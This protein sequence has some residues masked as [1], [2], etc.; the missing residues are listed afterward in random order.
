M[1]VREHRDDLTL[2]AQVLVTAIKLLLLGVASAFWMVQIVRGGHYRALAESNRLRSLPIQAPRGLIYDR[3][4][5]ILVEN[6]P[7]YDLLLDRGRSEDLTASLEHAATLLGRSAEELGATMERRRGANPFKPALVGEN[8]T[9]AEV[10][11]VSATGL[12]HPEFEIQVRHLRLYRLGYQTAH[13]LGH[14]GEVGAAELARPDSPYEP[15]DLVGRKGV[16]LVYDRQLQGRD[17][18]RVVVVDSRGKPLEEYS[19]KPAQAG[20]SLTLTLDVDLQ[21][22]AVRLMGDHVGVVVA[23][24]PR[25]GEVLALVSSPSYNP[26]H[27]A[28][29]LAAEEWRQLL[30]EPHDPLQNRA[31]QSSYSPGSLFKIVMA[32]AGLSEGVVRP[33]DTTYCSGATTLYNHRFRCWKR[34]GHGWMNLQQAI[35]HSCDVYFYYLGQKLGIERIAAYARL[36]GLGSPT[37]VDLRGEAGG[38]IPDLDWSRRVRGEPWYPGE[39]ISVSIGQGPLLVT[40]LQV[41]TMLAAVANGGRGVEPHLQLGAA[42]TRLTP[43]GLDPEALALVRRSLWSVVNEPEG[44]GRAARVPGLGVAG[45]TGTVQVVSQSTWVSSEDLPFEQRD[46]AWFGSFAPYDDPELVVVVFLEHGGKGSAAAAPVA[47]ALYEHFFATTAHDSRLAG[48]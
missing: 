21:Q 14:L 35:Q 5:Q 13:V 20:R 15:G 38:L 28:R 48:G 46:H 36:F 43:L 8:L 19:R 3:H 39:T 18:E 27:F 10:A 32:V 24:D 11:R 26:N 40:P 6:I 33:S 41:A 42:E 25:S 4:G 9:L 37:G 31:H 44:T 1:K 29:R 12:E 30:E 45:K 7:A 17:G 16:E 23:L 22:E 2:R 47:K 34:G